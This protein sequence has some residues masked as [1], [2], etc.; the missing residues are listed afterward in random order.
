MMRSVLTIVLAVGLVSSAAAR[1]LAT[2]EAGKAVVPSETLILLD[3]PYVESGH[4]R[5]KLDLY[6][7][8]TNSAPYPVIV[9]IHG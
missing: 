8:R 1:Q 2:D 3:L 9:W 5:N 6:I 4:E 7:P